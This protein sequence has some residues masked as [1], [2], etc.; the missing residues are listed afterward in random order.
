MLLLLDLDANK[1]DSSISVRDV[2]QNRR[3]TCNLTLKRVFA[4]IDAVEKQEVLRIMSVCVCV[5]ACVC[6]QHAM[7]MGHIA[8]CGLSRSTL[9]F[10]FFS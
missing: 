1:A 7:L 9:V 2:L 5:R 4:T 10:H 6:I 8:I 3:C